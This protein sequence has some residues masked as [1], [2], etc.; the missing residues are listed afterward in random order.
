MCF[1]NKRSLAWVRGAE[2]PVC[3]SCSTVE[4][5]VFVK[6]T[7][8]QG[9]FIQTDVAVANTQPNDFIARFTNHVHTE[10]EVFGEHLRSLELHGLNLLPEKS[11]NHGNNCRSSENKTLHIL[12]EFL[13]VNLLQDFDQSVSRG[14]GFSEVH[15][16][17]CVGGGM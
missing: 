2:R 3:A 12:I 7:P 16:K 5:T 11:S 17:N 4:G 1:R 6:H 10:V 14:K 9:I 8:V 15:V 13:I